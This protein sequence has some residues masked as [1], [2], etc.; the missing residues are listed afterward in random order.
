MKGHCFG[1]SK[2][3][4]TSKISWVSAQIALWKRGSQVP[5]QRITRNLTLL[6]SEKSAHDIS[7]HPHFRASLEHV[8]L[9]FG[10]MSTKHWI[11]MSSA[12]CFYL[13]M[14]QELTPQAGLGLKYWQWMDWDQPNDANHCHP[15]CFQ[16]LKKLAAHSRNIKKPEA[17]LQKSDKSF[18]HFSPLTPLDV[19]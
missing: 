9:G 11:W 5:N 8:A 4:R 19:P 18:N 7:W 2:V 3:H 1:T 12:K 15:N 6:S 14:C 17:H 10:I 16:G 13:W